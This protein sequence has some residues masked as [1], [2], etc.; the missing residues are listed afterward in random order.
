MKATQVSI[1]RCTDK[2][3]VYKYIYTHTN[4]ILFSQILP[5]VMTWIGLERIMLSEISQDDEGQ[6]WYD[7]TYMWNIKK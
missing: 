3:V 4:G 7:F 6:I 5:F 2:D 1:E